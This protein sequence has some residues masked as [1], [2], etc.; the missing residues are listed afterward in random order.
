M[1]SE[2]RRLV[3]FHAEM[4]EALKNFGETYDVAFPDGNMIKAALSGDTNH[5]VHTQKQI[6]VCFRS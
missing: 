5:E 6:N 3:F 4:T 1:P 2:V